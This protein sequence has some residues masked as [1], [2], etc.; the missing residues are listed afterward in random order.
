MAYFMHL[1]SEGDKLHFNGPEDDDTMFHFECFNP[2][3][4]PSDMDDPQAGLVNGQ[5]SIPGS[6][7]R[8][9]V[10]DPVI[11]QVLDLLEGQV[12]RG[13]H[14]GQRIEALLLVGGFAGSGYL[15]KRI[16]VRGS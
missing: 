10:F 16:E 1:F 3:P 7:L 4:N 8:Q 2:S 14:S 6:D 9:Q 13:Y 15:K 12:S 11:E 5:L